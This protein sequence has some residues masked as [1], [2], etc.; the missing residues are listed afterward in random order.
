MGSSVLGLGLCS[1]TDWGG[2][3]SGCPTPAASPGRG[4]RGC[5]SSTHSWQS[6]VV[7]GQMAQQLLHREQ[8]IGT[9]THGATASAQSPWV[10]QPGSPPG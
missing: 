5:P 9:G 1:A 6:L 7:G 8:Q 4:F 3:Y 10:P 2:D